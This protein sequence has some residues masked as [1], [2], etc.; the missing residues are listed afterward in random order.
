MLTSFVLILIAFGASVVAQSSTPIVVC[1]AGQCLQGYSNTT[2]GAKLSA[3]GAPTSIQLLPGQ[4]SSSTNPQLLHDA[5]T[6]SSASLSSSPGFENA[7]TAVSLPLNLALAPGLAIYSQKLYSGQAGFSQLP[8]APIVNLST[9]LSANS[10]V[11]A[12]SIWVAVG[13][14]GSNTRV[15]LWDAVPDVSQLPSGAASGLNLLDMQSSACSPPCAGSGVCSASGVC[16][17]PTG[18][19]GSSCESCAKGFF[20][21]TCQPCPSGCTSCDEGISGSGRCLVPVVTGAP[22]T[23]NC[24]NGQCGSNGQCTCNAGWTTAANG[25]ACAKCSPGFFLTSTGDC[26]VCQLGCT[27]CAD[28]SGT[29]IACKTGFTQDANDKTKCNAVQSVT[30]TGTVCPDG[31]FSNGT[32]CTPCSPTCKTC[33]AGTSNDCII[34]AA[35]QYMFN[36]HCVAANTNGVC[37]GSN[38]IADN[39][40][41]ECDTCGAKCTSCSIPG[42]NVASTVNQL[43]C[44]GCLPG[45][46]LSQGKCVSSC[47]AGTFISPQDNLTCVACDPSCSTCTGASTFCLTCANNQLASNGKC[48]TSCPSNSFT[49]TGSCVACHPDCATCS[50]PSFN[51]CSSCGPGRPVLTNGRCL[52][53]CSRS[54]F[55]DTTSS[56]CQP[57]DSSCSSCSGPGPS[58]CL[59][60]SSSSQVLRAGSCV[61]TNCVGSSSVVAGLG[62]CLSELVQV[63]TTS[64]NAPPLPSITGLSNP[65]VVVTGRRPLAWWEILLMALGCAFVF[66]MVLLCW[67]RRAKNQRAK[68][69]AMFAEAKN[70]Q[71]KGWRERLVRFGE[72]F[73][74]HSAKGRAAVLPVHHNPRGEDT[75]L[76]NL[77]DAEDARHERQVESFIDAYG[78]S[79]YP[80][81]RSS[82]NP[83]T[84]PSLREYHGKNPSI[85]NPNRLSSGLS[86][87]SEVTGKPRQAAEPRQP[88]KKDA[89]V[90]RFS[91]STL[92]SSYSNWTRDRERVV[93]APP[94]LPTEAEEYVMVVRPALDAW[95]PLNPNSNWVQLDHTGNS[96][97]PFRK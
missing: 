38:L 90:S 43:Q 41:N 66:L 95:P 40:K 96:R 30:S 21:P 89:L 33:T 97:N 13:S 71:G 83:S 5:I 6:S 18:F 79:R 87:Y 49:A 81:S 34:C 39:N 67:R 31:S 23:C 77:K 91:S 94:P 35:G 72:R 51:Q 25:T 92:S 32:T 54:Q 50:G 9:P 15:V 73:F 80:E 75:K 16:T 7:T 3:A 93:L 62:V 64:G 36:G 20:G 76:Q 22:A 29:C 19:T 63:P 14:K 47:P 68:R 42:F 69:T 8:S 85:R 58:N 27:Q 61:A 44:T 56:S 26:Q 28:E 46:V 11:I 84:L 2:I 17:C 88:V 82:R 10:L 57:C 86:L 4:Y 70:L 37:A 45:F 52:P 1:V 55:F 24:L 60:C 74:G 12:S 78:Y 53:T 48:V 59:A 65:T